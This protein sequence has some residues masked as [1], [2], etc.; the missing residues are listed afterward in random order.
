MSELSKEKVMEV[1][2][3]FQFEGELIE[4]KRWGNGHINDTFLLVYKIGKMGHL[5]AI[6]QMMNKNV[7]PKPV[8]L[9]ENIT[10][11]TSFL[12]KKIEAAGGDP[13]R[14]TLN[15]IPAK[16]GLSYYQDAD[17]EYWRAYIYVTDA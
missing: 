10:G 5:K 2:K 6:L 7:F 8:E 12:Y 9:M 14:E 15:V 17:G 13:M 4:V 16:D 3:H 1:A 11:V